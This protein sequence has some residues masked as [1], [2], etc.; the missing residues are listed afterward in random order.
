M[1]ST[2]NIAT[3]PSPG[4]LGHL[5]GQR[6]ELKPHTSAA[7]TTSLD[8]KRQIESHEA[9]SP[10]LRTTIWFIRWVWDFEVWKSQSG[11]TFHFGPH[12]V[13]ST[14][15]EI[16]RFIKTGNEQGIQELLER[17][18]ISVNDVFDDGRSLFG[19][20]TLANYF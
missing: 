17:R 12:N 20:S 3:I 8:L 16:Y 10:R 18:Q 7:S 9:N 6:R 15:S 13:I 2:S 11:W 5:F 19:V 4:K 14:D 1:V